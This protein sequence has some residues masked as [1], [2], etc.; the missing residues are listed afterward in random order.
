MKKDFELKEQTSINFLKKYNKNACVC[1]SGGK[2][3]LVA[4][5][6]AIKTGIDSVVF[7][8]T[9]MEFQ[10]TIDYIRRVEEF[11]DIKVESVT[12]PVPFFELVH[13][14]GFPS[15]SMRWCCKVYK[16][17]PLAIF[18]RE[19]KIVSYVTG[20]RGEEHARRKNY[21]KNDMNKHIKIKQINPI[22]D[23]SNQEV[24]AYI[25]TNKLPTNPL[26]KLGFKR[27]G[28]WPCPF[29]TKT[30][31]NII[32]EHFPDK[33]I[34]L[35]NTL[36][37]IFKY[38]KGLGIKNIDDFIKNH[39]WT[40]YRR[41]QNSE[42]K[43][44]IEVM[45]EITF[46]NL[47]NSHQIKRVENV[48]PI[49]SKDYEIIRNSIVIKKKLQRQKVKIL[50]EKALNCVGCGACVAFCKS[51]SIKEDTL[52][53]DYNSCNSCLKCINTRLMRGACIVRNYSPFRFEVNTCKNMIFEKEFSQTPIKPEMRVGL[54][55]T[56]NSLELLVEKLNGIA[57]IKEYDHYISIKNGTFKA[58][59]YK[60]NGFAEIKVYSNNNELEKAMND[61]R[62]ALT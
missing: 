4:L 61:I 18:A 20:L 57:A 26:Y 21:K 48:I 51:M 41:P 31:W 19:K 50:V 6:L 17:S 56:R 34:F 33:Y 60:S 11:Y 45:P 16:F 28:C 30:D 42:L 46:I 15:R 29:K 52:F 8:D 54:I 12:A 49:L 35:Q 36:R 10:E 9:T 40:A 43:G 58:T 62:K 27:V 14:I 25:H 37:I 7:C 23:W 32:E 38:C 5:D 55:R 39:K 3:S 13:K 2:D 44:K 53:I 1:F 47:E 22:L 24:W 59:A